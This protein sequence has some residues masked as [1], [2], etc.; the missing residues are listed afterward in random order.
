[1][2]QP[3]LTDFSIW[4][5]WASIRTLP[6]APAPVIVPL[7]IAGLIPAGALAARTKPSTS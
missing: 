3:P 5:S 4:L 2:T 1:M 7:A 6:V